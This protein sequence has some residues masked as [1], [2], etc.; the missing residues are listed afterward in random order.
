MGNLISIENNISL[1]IAFPEFIKKSTKRGCGVA[2][3]DVQ[4][5][6]TVHNIKYSDTLTTLV[7]DS[8]KTYVSARVIGM[9]RMYLGKKITQTCETPS[10]FIYKILDILWDRTMIDHEN[11]Q[12]YLVI[13]KNIF[14][15]NTCELRNSHEDTIGAIMFIRE[16]D[17]FGS[18][19][20]SIQKDVFNMIQYTKRQNSRTH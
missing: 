20:T 14:F 8:N 5:D 17:P 11:L 13:D 7:I 9:L 12:T 19:L 10:C 15:V 3:I 6:Y 18:S 2:L 4:G 1:A 16:F